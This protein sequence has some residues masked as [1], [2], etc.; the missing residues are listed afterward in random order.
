MGGKTVSTRIILVGGFLGAGKTTLLARAAEL[1]AGSGQRVGLVT[2][3]QAANLVDTVVLKQ[4]GHA[5]REVPGGCFCCKLDDF[6]TAAGQLLD[7]EQID[8]ILAEPVGS[9]TDLSATVLQPLKDRHGSRFEI[10]PFSVLVDVTQVRALLHLQ[11]FEASA[12]GPRPLPESV[13]YIYRKQIE[14]ADLIVLNKI[15]RLDEHQL[16]E[17]HAALSAE[18]ADTPCFAI[19]ARNNTGVVQWLRYAMDQPEG[20]RTVAQVDYDIYAEGEAVLGWLNAAMSIS[21]SSAVD[22][23]EWIDRFLECFRR[24]CATSGGQIAHAKLLLESAQGTARAHLVAND[25]PLECIGSLT[26]HC[27]TCRLVFN[28]RVHLDPASLRGVFQQALDESLD[29]GSRC[30][31]LEIDV[32]SPPRPRPPYRYERPV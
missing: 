21:A 13:L 14:E 28:A 25:Q 10:G 1:L 27:D 32:F 15:D 3:D 31:Q 29:E 8:V 22:W 19:S 11:Q 26:G 20:G 12:T 17:L 9:C 24:H 16:Q 6:V 5:V 4:Y 18:F 30:K 23:T 2:N 7:D